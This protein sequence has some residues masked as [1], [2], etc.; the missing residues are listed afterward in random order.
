MTWESKRQDLRAKAAIASRIH[1]LTNG[2]PGDVSQVGPVSELSIHHSPG[3]CVE[4]Q[5]RGKEIVILRCGGDKSSQTKDTATVE[6]LANEWR[7]Q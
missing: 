3:Y 1:R 7:P 5:Q 4:F 6:R 2:L